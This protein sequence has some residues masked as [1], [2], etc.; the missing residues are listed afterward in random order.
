M[1]TR[2]SGGRQTSGIEALEQGILEQAQE[3]AAR[4]LT[5]AEA[6]ARIIRQQ[7]Q[8]QA[9]A[10]SRL[11]VQRA[12]EEAKQF[13]DHALANAQLEAQTLK[14]KRR[15]QL[16]ARV[17]AAAREQLAAVQQWPE[18]DQVVLHLIREAIEHLAADAV[19]VRSDPFTHQILEGSNL[20][21]HLENETG[22][23]IQ[24]GETLPRG[25]GVV[26][27]T[28][29]GHR[30]FDNTLETRLSRLQDSLRAPVYHILTEGKP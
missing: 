11:I 6:K 1:S 13:H 21:S 28:L 15:E 23:H 26:V 30:R 24:L 2:S 9:E 16:L 17:F 20:L 7:A 10:E 4:L 3:E 18:Y 27:E 12:Q 22:V 8:T 19:R 25:I 5:D 29:D 14:L